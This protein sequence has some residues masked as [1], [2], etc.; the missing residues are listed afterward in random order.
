MSG[1][2]GKVGFKAVWRMQNRELSDV[3]DTRREDFN[4]R[5]VTNRCD[6]YQPDTGGDAMPQDDPYVLTLELH[7]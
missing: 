7:H 1:I 5:I 3:M 2:I 4:R 6:E